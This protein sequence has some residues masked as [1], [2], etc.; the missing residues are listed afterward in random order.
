MLMSDPHCFLK[1]SEEPRGKIKALKAFFTVYRESTPNRRPALSLHRSVYCSS[2][3]CHSSNK[4]IALA[5]Q[6]TEIKER[7]ATQKSS[8][9][10]LQLLVQK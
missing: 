2:L 6:P 5:S 9:F 4:I 8:S 3:T 7:G 10:V 1:Y